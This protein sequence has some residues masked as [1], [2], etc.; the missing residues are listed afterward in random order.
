MCLLCLSDWHS[1]RRELRHCGGCSSRPEVA[2]LAPVCFAVASVGFLTEARARGAC[3]LAVSLVSGFR[4]DP[5][6]P[7]RG[8]PW[9]VPADPQA[10]PRCRC[11]EPNSMNGVFVTG[12]NC[13]GDFLLPGPEY[14]RR[15]AN[16]LI[17]LSVATRDPD[18]GG[19]TFVAGYRATGDG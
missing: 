18:T 6:A 4:V 12:V 8:R 7:H 2:W 13:R 17:R 1:K 9:G 5:G 11:T 19:R 10:V 14:H 15:Q 16:I 3:P